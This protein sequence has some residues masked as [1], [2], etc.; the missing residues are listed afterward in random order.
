MKRI[1]SRFACVLACLPVVALAQSPSRLDREAETNDE[2]ERGIYFRATAGAWFLL[3][4]PAS[5]GTPQPF[6]PGQLVQLELGAD[7]GERLAIGLLLTGT[8]NRAGSDYTGRSNGSSSG[9]FSALIPGAALRVNLVGFDDAQQVQRTWIYL[10]AGGG[11]AMFS[12]KVLLPEADIML[13]GGPGIEYFTRLRH[14]SIG[15]EVA[16]AFLLNNASVGFAV[17]PHLRYAF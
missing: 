10:R 11:Y 1:P 12:P 14:F 9:D 4:A 15:L 13:F 17:T 6:S 7:I 3:N 8:F 5:P 2:V 16:A